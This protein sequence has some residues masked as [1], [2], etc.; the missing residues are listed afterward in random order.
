MLIGS[1]EVLLPQLRLNLNAQLVM[2][3]PELLLLRDF[4]GLKTIIFKN[5]Q[6]NRS[7]TVLVLLTIM[8]AE[9]VVLKTHIIMHLIILWS[10]GYL[11]PTM[12]L[13]VNAKTTSKEFLKLMVSELSITVIVM[14][15]RINFRLNPFQSM[16]MLKTSTTI[17][18]ASSVTAEML[19][20]W[21]FFWWDQPT[22]IGD[23]R[24]VGGQLG[25]E[26][27]YSSF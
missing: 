5:F 7:L 9:E 19:P 17:T 20:T 12:H 24:T 15:L 25:R 1:Q 23:W 18:Q 6:T 14:L 10:W 11:I 27:I 16:L 4:I 8:D 2:L 3:L 21:I 13:K 22:S 26:W